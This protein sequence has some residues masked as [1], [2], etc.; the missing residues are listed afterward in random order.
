MSTPANRS[1][2]VFAERTAVLRSS[3]VSLIFDPV[4]PWCRLDR[5]S[6][7]AGLFDEL[8][9]QDVRIELNERTHD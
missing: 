2:S 1:P 8:L 7:S 4:P 9:H 3:G 5:N 6:P